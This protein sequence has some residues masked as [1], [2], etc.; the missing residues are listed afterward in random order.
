MNNNN[1]NLDVNLIALIVSWVLLIIAV[2]YLV[3]N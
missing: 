2:M 3:L 1:N